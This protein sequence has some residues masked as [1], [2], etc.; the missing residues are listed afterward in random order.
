MPYFIDDIR[1][2]RADLDQPHAGPLTGGA[3]KLVSILS[4]FGI[5]GLVVELYRAQDKKVVFVVQQE[6]E[7][8]ARY[9]VECLLPF[10]E[11]HA[12][13]GRED[14]RHPHFTEYIRIITRRLPKHAKE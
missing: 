11:C 1:S 14:I 9:F 7:M 5:M 12:F 3:Q 2:F 4:V 6:I 10:T 13:P 8:L